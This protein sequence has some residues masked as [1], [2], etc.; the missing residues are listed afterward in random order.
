MGGRPEF[1]DTEG[2]GYE[3]YKHTR[4]KFVPSI[5][6]ATHPDETAEYFKGLGIRVRGFV[7]WQQVRDTSGPRG[8]EGPTAEAPKALKAKSPEE[9]AKET[10]C[11]AH[12]N[13]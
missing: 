8:P 7:Q 5:V 9:I 12:G 6:A 2:V 3:H 1:D 13:C 11:N 10:A 4:A